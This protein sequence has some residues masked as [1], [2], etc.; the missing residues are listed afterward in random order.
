MP[1]GRGRP[2][3]VPHLRAAPGLGAVRF[4]FDGD[5]AQLP[6]LDAELSARDP[7]EAYFQALQSSY[8]L[9]GEGH[10]GFG[11]PAAAPRRASGRLVGGRKRARQG[12]TPVCIN[13]HERLHEKDEPTCLPTPLHAGQ[14]A[15]AAQ[16]I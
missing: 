15:L 4:R 7:E 5:V 9:P 6:G 14:P 16:G 3:R 1:R 10:R 13:L 2:V 11:A 12:E 8:R